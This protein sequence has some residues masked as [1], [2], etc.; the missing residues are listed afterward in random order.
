METLHLT[1]DENGSIEM[2]V[3]RISNPNSKI[4]ITLP[5][6]SFLHD[7]ETK[8]YTNHSDHS[9]NDQT[10]PLLEKYKLVEDLDFILQLSKPGSFYFQVIKKTVQGPQIFFLVDPIVNIGGKQ[11]P[12]SGI[13]IQTTYARCIGKLDKWVENLKPIADLGYNMLHLPP[14]QAP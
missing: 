12:L 7:S 10:I 9:G 8:I 11:I 1:L 13:N 14:Y 2:G 6:G 4:K 3:I 5:V